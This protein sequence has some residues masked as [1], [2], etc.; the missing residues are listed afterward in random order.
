M[1]KQVEQSNKSNFRHPDVRP[2][3]CQNRARS[4]CPNQINKYMCQTQN[5]E[6][7]APVTVIDRAM[8][9]YSEKSLTLMPPP[10]RHGQS[11]NLSKCELEVISTSTR[12]EQDNKA[13][14]YMDEETNVQYKCKYGL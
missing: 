1:A 13:H 8:P 5:K 14:I 12:V 2:M 10:K 4:N 3:K 6:Y 11:L 7:I 9:L